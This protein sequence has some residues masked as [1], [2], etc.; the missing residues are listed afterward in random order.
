LPTPQSNRRGIFAIIGGMAFFAGNDAV[1]KLVARVA[2]LGEVLFVR[3]LMTCVLVAVLMVAFG[4]ATQL[5]SAV[6]PRVVARSGLEALAALLFTSALIR[7]PLAELSTI[8][9]A[10]PLIITVL[11]VALYGEE[12]GWRRW[13]AIIVGFAGAL[14]V[15]KPT[16]AA[17]NAW[18][19]VGLACAFTSACRD[20]VT[21][22]LPEGVPFTVVSLM[23]A[24]SVT[25]VGLLMAPW[26]SWRPLSGAELGVLALGAV[27]LAGGTM[28]L[29][30]AFRDVD[31]SAVAP[32]RYTLLI[33]AGLAGYF[34]FGEL[35]DSWSATGAALIVGSGVYAL[36]REAMRARM[37]RRNAAAAVNGPPKQRPV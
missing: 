15:V 7:M 31:V 36:H 37:A 33:W 6:H 23:A 29:V 22:R 2:P 14:C 25:L 12:V 9:L 28:L 21:R 11:A 18:A 4:H 1:V 26:E 16:P 27:F 17:F 10:S 19:L 35:P 5:R 8:V 34:L 13:T 24:V 20:L 30:L 3:G 32:F